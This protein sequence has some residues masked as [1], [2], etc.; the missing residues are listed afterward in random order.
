MLDFARDIIGNQP[1]LTAFLAIGLGYLVG[2]ISVAG[3]SLGV[4]AVLLDTLAIRAFPRKA[5]TIGP[6]GLT[7]LIFFLDGIDIVSGRQFVEGILGSGQK[8][9]LL[10]L[11]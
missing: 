10:A 7:A 9:N 8:Y 5:Q 2:Q 11:V 3:V 6:I 4:G 1:I